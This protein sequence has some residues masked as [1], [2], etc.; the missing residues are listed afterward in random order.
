[1]SSV[2]GRPIKSTG[3][4]LQ[5]GEDDSSSDSDHESS[6]ESGEMKSLTLCI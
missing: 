4:C 5:F 2:S 6:T 1:M 3:I